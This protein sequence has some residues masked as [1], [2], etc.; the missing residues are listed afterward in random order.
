MFSFRASK[1]YVYPKARPAG[2]SWTSRKTPSAPAAIP[3]RAMTGMKPGSPPEDAPRP[4]GRWTLCEASKT[5][6]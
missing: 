6:G 5:T 2:R 1:S 3:A 4:P